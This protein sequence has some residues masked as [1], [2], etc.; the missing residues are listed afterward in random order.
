MLLSTTSTENSGLLSEILPQF[1]A[2]TGIEVAVVARGTG[3]ALRAGERGDGDV[4]LVHARAAEEAFV[5]AGHGVKRFDVM[6]NDFLIAGPLADPA[7]VA[8]ATSAS[9][10]FRRIATAKALF[11]SRGDDSGT[12]KK[13]LDLWKRAGIDPAG[14][15]G[16][17]YRETG[18]GM[19]AT[20]NAAVGMEAYVLTD[21]GTWIS[22]KNKRDLVIHFEGDPVLFNPYGAILVNPERHPSVKAAEG[23]RL[24]DWLIGPE[25]QRAI[26]AF[27]IGGQQLF[28]PSSERPTP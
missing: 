1:T 21:R 28:Y 6:Y 7:G 5:A 2:A 27:R 25:G 15:S 8:A 4:L 12:H 3:E 9:D 17:W 13:E 11:A 26:A 10:A 24:I 18:S 14:A 22:F 16:T 23:Q 19:G 20:L